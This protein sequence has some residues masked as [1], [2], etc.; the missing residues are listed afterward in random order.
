M[1]WMRA[2]LAGMLMLMVWVATAAAGL[3]RSLWGRRQWRS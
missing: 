1:A 2:K 3:I